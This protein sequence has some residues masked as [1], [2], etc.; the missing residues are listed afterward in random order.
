MA[1]IIQFP[2]ITKLDMNPQIIL[3][4]A[5]EAEMTEVIVVGFDKDG[6]EYFASSKADAGSV[7]YHFQRAIH[8]LMKIIDD[9]IEM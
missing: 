8:A 2:G 9:M 4:K 6:N 3:Q 7:L 5:L 1:K